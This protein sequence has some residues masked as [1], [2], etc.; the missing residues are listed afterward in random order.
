[1]F[2]DPHKAAKRAR[3]KNA[4]INQRNQAIKGF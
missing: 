2:E 3:L 1:M 4:P